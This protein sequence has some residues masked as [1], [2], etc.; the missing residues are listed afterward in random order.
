MGLTLHH[1][2]ADPIIGSLYLGSK[3]APF[4]QRRGPNHQEKM[5]N[6]SVRARSST[7]KT[8]R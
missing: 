8:S 6:Y 2:K 1:K 5:M 4:L 7:S 3:A